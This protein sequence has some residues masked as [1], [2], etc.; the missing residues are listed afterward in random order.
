MNESIYNSYEGAFSEMIELTMTETPFKVA[1]VKVDGSVKIISKALLRKQTPTSKDINGAYKFNL[2]DT[3]N[4]NY[5]TAYIPLLTS[6]ND[7]QIQL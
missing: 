7:K 3:V 4:N 2:V 6:V 5:V 1:F